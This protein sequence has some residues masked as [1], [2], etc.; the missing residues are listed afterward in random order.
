MR[1]AMTT[2]PHVFTGSYHWGL[3]VLSVVIAIVAPYAALDLAGRVTSARGNVRFPRRNRITSLKFG[4]AA[5]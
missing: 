3:I 2:S 4:S 1:L 5:L